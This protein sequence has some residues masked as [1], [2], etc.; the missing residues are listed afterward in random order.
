[1][2]SVKEAL[3]TVTLFPDGKNYTQ[4][5]AQ[6]Y[7]NCITSPEHNADKAYMYIKVIIIYSNGW[8]NYMLPSVNSTYSMNNS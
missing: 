4:T 5:K 7:D 3:L 6:V 2:L 1:M 8:C